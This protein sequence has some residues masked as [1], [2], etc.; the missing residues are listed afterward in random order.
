MFLFLKKTYERGKI[1]CSSG[2]Y[3]IS[4]FIEMKGVVI[5]IKVDEMYNIFKSMLVTA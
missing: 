5:L 2:F 4:K 3:R 1:H